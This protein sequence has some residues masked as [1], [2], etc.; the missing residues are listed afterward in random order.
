MQESDP[1]AKELTLQSEKFGFVGNIHHDCGVV[2][3]QD[4]NQKKSQ[5]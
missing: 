3:K 1:A 5:H 4:Q 2:T